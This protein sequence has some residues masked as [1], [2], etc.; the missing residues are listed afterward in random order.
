MSVRSSAGPGESTAN[1]LT[2]EA[3]FSA[4][5]AQSMR[6]GHF[7]TTER[8]AA[9]QG[10]SGAQGRA[11]LGQPTNRPASAAP[12]AA[13]RTPSGSTTRLRRV[14][15]CNERRVD[16]PAVRYRRGGTGRGVAG[17]LTWPGERVLRSWA[18]RVRAVS[19]GVGGGGGG[20][21][22]PG[23]RAEHD[24]ARVGRSQQLRPPGTPHLLLHQLMAGALTRSR[25]RRPRSRRPGISP[26]RASGSGTI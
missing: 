23:D 11:V 21:R 2:A 3:S 24:P 22:L 26:G 17:W 14:V 6:R 1:G 18:D 7:A 19:G 20:D 12:D 15:G 10:A 5:R 16:T 4:Q 8:A 9:P 13:A 25:S